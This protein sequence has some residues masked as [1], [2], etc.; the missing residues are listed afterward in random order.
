M[1][2]TRDGTE[3]DMWDE[4]RKEAFKVKEDLLDLLARKIV[5]ETAEAQK[6]GKKK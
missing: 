5:H 4:V 3:R 1:L 2:R 6:R